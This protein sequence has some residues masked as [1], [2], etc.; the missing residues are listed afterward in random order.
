MDEVDEYICSYLSRNEN[1]TVKGN[2]TAKGVANFLM[3]SIR[4]DAPD[5]YYVNGRT[6][7][8]FEHFKIDYSKHD[9]NGSSF[10]RDLAR[11][12][13]KAEVYFRQHPY[14]S[15][16]FRSPLDFNISSKFY[17]ETLLNSFNEHYAR[18]DRYIHNV[19]SKANLVGEDY[20][21]KISFIV[22]DASPLGAIKEVD[23]LPVVPFRV[24]EFMDY[25]R[26]LNRID[27]LICS[28]HCG[29]VPYTYIMPKEEFSSFE[30]DEY[31]VLKTAII[32]VPPNCIDLHIVVKKP[33]NE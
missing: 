20:E 11:D 28:W 21:F 8:L 29:R 33:D 17:L 18:I 6:V 22:E 7:Y 3:K 13:R 25:L 14:E 5:R 16:V 19:E 12:E 15:R 9:K 4:Y 32:D 10:V 31:E 30:H 1:V 23:L 26:S 2:G 24:K 27:F